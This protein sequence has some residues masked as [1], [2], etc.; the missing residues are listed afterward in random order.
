IEVGVRLVDLGNSRPVSLAEINIV[1][2]DH[3][4]VAL[5]G[6]VIH[7]PCRNV[8][9]GRLGHDNRENML[10]TLINLARS[11]FLARAE[12][13]GATSEEDHHEHQ[14]DTVFHIR[15]RASPLSNREIV[16]AQRKCKGTWHTLAQFSVIA[17]IDLS[18]SALVSLCFPFSEAIAIAPRMVVRSSTAI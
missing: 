8:E 7:Y 4:M 6:L 13:C 3:F 16:R 15:H 18:P 17:R 12:C 14:E 5:H 9:T 10:R 2:S 11:N 1:E